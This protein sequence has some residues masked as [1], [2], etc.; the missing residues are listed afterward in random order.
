MQAAPQKRRESLIPQPNAA[1]RDPSKCP[2]AA[3]H[4]TS[5]AFSCLEPAWVKQQLAA[6]EV[7]QFSSFDCLDSTVQC[8]CTLNLTRCKQQHPIAS[9]P[10]L[11]T[12][13]RDAR[14][15]SGL[16]MHRASCSLY[17]PL[18]NPP[19]QMLTRLPVCSA[20][21]RRDSHKPA[22]YL[23]LKLDHQLNLARA[24]PVKGHGGSAAA[25]VSPAGAAPTPRNTTATDADRL[26]LAKE[27]LI[28]PQGHT[29]QRSPQDFTIPAAHGPGAAQLGAAMQGLSV[30]ATP[31]NTAAA[32]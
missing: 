7:L 1:P 2:A 32:S 26:A 11:P 27:I 30:S 13:H 14:A 29:M 31:R 10:G 4:L 5:P 16:I 19:P 6:L 17:N 12:L 15:A 22:E 8:P 9:I 21:E 20:G 25:G 24:Q 28:T 3:E 23:E 18:S